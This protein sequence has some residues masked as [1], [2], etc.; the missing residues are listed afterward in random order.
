MNQ[1]SIQNNVG[2]SFNIRLLVPSSL[3]SSTVQ[4]QL[5]FSYLDGQHVDQT[6]SQIISLS[7]TDFTSPITLLTNS[8]SLVAGYT[9]KPT[10]TIRNTGDSP[11]SS[12]EV[13]VSAG[14]S[15]SS[16]ISITPGTEKWSFSSIKSHSEATV[17]PQVLT[18]LGSADTLQGLTL[19]L[20]YLDSSGNWHKE[21]RAIGF[22]VK[23]S[24]ILLF[25]GT[26]ATPSQVAPGSNFTLTGNILNTGNTDALF[27]NVTL[28]ADSRFRTNAEGTQ[29]LGNIASNT[30]I[31]FSITV[32]SNRTLSNRVYPVTVMIVYQDSY[33]KQYVQ[34][35]NVQVSISNTIQQTTQQTVNTTPADFGTFRIIFLVALVAIVVVGVFF[36]LR[37]YRGR[38]RM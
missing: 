3:A 27:S 7:V 33:G 11:L 29:Y 32:T 26:A 34:E 15:S 9:N 1:G 22:T 17:M 16:A 20:T 23:G 14:T 2:V 38:K 25:Q 36:A 19:T 10:I 8:D 37:V 4:V 24:I 5:L 35:T 13:T 30:P 18:S 6:Q 21:T 31:P 12:I 28:K